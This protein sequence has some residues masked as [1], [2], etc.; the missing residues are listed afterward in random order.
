MTR[1]VRMTPKLSVGEM[2]V[3]E[4]PSC[5]A[6]ERAHPEHRLYCSTCTVNDD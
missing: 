1:R 6:T 3:F 4:C 2:T 5:G